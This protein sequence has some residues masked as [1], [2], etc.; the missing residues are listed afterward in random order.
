[1]NLNET[2]CM[3][4]KYLLITPFD[5]QKVLANGL[6]IREARGKR[7]IIIGVIEASEPGLKLPEKAVCW[8]PIYAGSEIQVGEKAYLAVPFEDIIMIE[9]VIE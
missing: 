1:M 9:R 5:K 7:D 4:N 3:K 6:N 8:F 2:V